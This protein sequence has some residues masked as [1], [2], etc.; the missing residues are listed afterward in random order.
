MSEY[1]YETK[2]EIPK[3]Q[4]EAFNG[5]N[6]AYMLWP[7]VNIGLE[8]QE[9]K[10]P[11][12]RIVIVHGFGEYSQIYYRMMDQLA[13]NGFETF[14][15][16]QRGSGE[17]SP[18]KLK[19]ITNEYHTFND[20]DYFLRKNI[21]ECKEKG[22]PIHLWG[23]SMGGGIILNYACDGKHKNDVATF[24]ASG[25]LVVL[26]P[27]SQPNILTQFAAP[28]LAKFLPNMR[29]DTGLDLDGITSDPTYREFLANDPMSIPLY[30]SFRQI[31]DFL[32]RGKKLYKNEN[33]R[34]QK[35][36]KPLFIQ[37]GKDDTINDPKGSQKVYDL[38]AAPEKK[39]EFYNKAR[40]S[41]LSLETDEIYSNV[42]DDLVGW[43]NEYSE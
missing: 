31:Q 4:F 20:L 38:S 29:I 39:I 8:D 6:F 13:L 19:G 24:I 2:T 37:H 1:P 10:L 17:T 32:V 9:S 5:A 26:H 12:G 27:H 36:D 15:F 3:I 35:M 25:P 41:I 14:M 18:G 11:K 28:L 43:L 7:A 16:D 30:G 40:H 33:N 34:L 21:D 42:F 23:H 22:I